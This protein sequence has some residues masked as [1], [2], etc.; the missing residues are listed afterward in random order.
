VWDGKDFKILKKMMQAVVIVKMMSFFIETEIDT[1]NFS[2][3]LS[4]LK[5]KK[6]RNKFKTFLLKVKK[7]VKMDL[8]SKY[9][10]KYSVLST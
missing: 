5:T 9:S 1:N 4:Q 3:I 6:I 7:L 8:V 10:K 2:K